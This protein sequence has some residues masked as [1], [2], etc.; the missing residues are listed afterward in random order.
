MY[1]LLP[2]RHCL[3]QHAEVCP[4]QN[5]R[6]QKKARRRNKIKAVSLIFSDLGLPAHTFIHNG[7]AQ[8]AYLGFNWVWVILVCRCGGANK[9]EHLS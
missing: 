4:P 3:G 5:L 2:H 6:L 1:F 7:G 9:K 8:L